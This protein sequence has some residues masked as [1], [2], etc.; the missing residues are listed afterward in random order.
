[1]PDSTYIGNFKGGLKLDRLPFNIDNDQFPT[2][3]N[4]YSWRGRAKR[5]RGTIFLGQLRIQEQIAASPLPWQEASFSL[6]SGAGN[7]ITQ[8]SLGSPATLT[9]GTFNLT[10]AGDQT[11][12]D[13]NFDGT[14]KGSTGG[15]GTINYVTGAFVAGTTS[16]S[17]TGTFS[18]FPGNPV[19]GLREFVSTTVSSQYPLLIAFDTTN[20]YGIN[21]TGASV[22]FYNVSFY[23]V[24]NN[25]VFWTGQ[26]FQQFWTTNYSSA[27]WAT[28]N[29]PGFQFEPI[30]AIAVGAVTTITTSAPHG[31]VTGDYVWFNEITGANAASLNGKTAQVTVTSPTTFTVPI[32]TTGMIITSSGI[33]QTLTA[34]STTSSGDGIRW[35]DGDPTGGTGLPTS[36]G[37]G[38]VNFSP[39]LSATAVTIDNIASGTTPFYLVGALLIVPYKDRL[40]FFSPWIQT[41]SGS[42]IQLQDVCLWSWNGTPYYA[43]LTPTGET[44]D[45]TAYYVDQTGKGGYIAAGI[46]QPILTVTNNEDVLL[47]GFPRRQSRFV[48]T[49]NDLYPFLF[50]TINTELGTE[51][52]FSGITLDRGGITLGSKGIVLTT[53]QSSE[54][55]DLDI[56]DN[57]FQVQA[58]NNG[59]LRVNAVRDF[60]REW[61]YFTYP[62][63][64]GNT[65][66]S[67]WVFPTRTFLWN[68]RD[69]T[70]AVLRENFTAQG[71]YRKSTH[72]TWA[73]LPFK[74]W[75][76]WREAWNSGS[77]TALFPSI[78]GGNPQGYVLIKGQGTGEGMSGTI[79]TITNAAGVTQVGST[80][81]CVNI[82][83]YLYFQG[84]ISTTQATITAISQAAQAVVT[85]SNTFSVG[86]YVLFS[87]VVGMTQIN[88]KNAQI[89]EA[90][91]T[92]FTINLDTTTFTA[93]ASGGLATFMP[94]QNQIGLVLST[95][96]SNTFT[97]DILFVSATYDGLGTYT[98]LSQP[99]I[100]TKQF[101]FYWDQG[102][103]AILKVQ[104][105]L[106]DYTANSQV[107]I[108]IYLSQDPDD[109][110]N[111]P[112]NNPFVP[113]NSLIYSQILFTCPE[114]QNIGLTPANT[115]L[116][117]PTA[118]S[119]YQIW[120]RIN[121]SLIGDSFQIGLT[122]S[123]AQ[124]RNL[125]FATSEIGLHG[126][127]LVTDKGPQL[128]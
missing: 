71:T 54:R 12:T 121:T 46:P 85:A 96:T 109:A 14:L 34:T 41:S 101:P 58:L 52:T 108:N 56:P 105:Y 7:L 37:Q 107:T 49:G 63:G 11:Y 87:Q 110:W 67:S 61:M 88:G 76:Q 21:Q 48:Y 83:D 80:N 114:E 43:G 25:P 55:I 35:Y 127:I 27:M 90:S 97:V 89:T 122:L 26:N 123:D 128:A 116:Q 1:M 50:F 24:S 2:L 119:Q 75:A 29:K 103:Q 77:T 99:L 91:A 84:A 60:F 10:V 23:K 28:N 93:Y 38:W 4:A 32:N 65:S 53:Q 33:F 22:T 30:S 39:P 117:M 44:S 86:Q 57:V 72:Y 106:M 78:I 51:S 18:Y 47:V 66:D 73:T 13:P 115:N 113:K 124:M 36:S 16:G 3:F 31:L 125:T 100:Q 102:R 70:W 6:V 59:V 64:D 94:M 126:I 82:G 19:M 5:K 69:N 118:S 8:Y 95:P 45:I 15:T 74:T 79:Q 81:H 68:Y 98:R 17:V 120:H 62:T 42:P 40:L 92:S 112:V 111:D 104:K 20:S 9:P